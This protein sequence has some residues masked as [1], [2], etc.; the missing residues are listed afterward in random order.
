MARHEM[1][2]PDIGEGIAEAEIVEWHAKIGDLIR[3]DQPIVSVMTDKA[4][5]ELPATVSGTLLWIGADVGQSVAIGSVIARIE[6]EGPA[7]KAVPPSLA[8]PEQEIEQE[9]RDQDARQGLTRDRSD[10]EHH[11]DPIAAAR[12]DSAGNADRGSEVMASPAVRRLAKERGIDL[13][14][15]AGSGPGGRV[16]EADL[17]ALS[18]GPDA[19][20]ASAASERITDVPVR[21]VRRA[22]AQHVSMSYARIPHITIV[23]E[24]DVTALEELRG[25]LNGKLPEGQTRLTIL[26][27]LTRATALA[28]GRVPNVNAHYDEEHERIRQYGNVHVGIA[29]QTSQGLMVPVVRDVEARDVWDCARE[30]SRLTEK[31]RNGAS[32]RDELRGSTITISSLGALGAV[33]TTPIINHPEV[34]IVGVN[35]IA[36]RPHWDGASFVPRKMMNLSSSF[37]HRVVDGWEAA[38]FVAT[39]KGLIEEPSRL[40]ART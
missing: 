20:K 24:V 16:T 33:A 8:A 34:A 32:A 11:A 25:A 27:F 31:A 23:E 26:P 39:L 38:Q 19:V 29:T 30:I 37:D 21:G 18:A 1:T 12:E 14:Q 22:I 36:T 15:V 5:V 3:E 6:T 40:L 7:E 10:G 13:R 9:T 28:I 17:A 35:R 4:T 2:L